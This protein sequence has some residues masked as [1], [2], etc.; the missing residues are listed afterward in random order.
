[1]EHLPYYHGFQFFRHYLDHMR[2]PYSEVSSLTE[3]INSADMNLRNQLGIAY[4]TPSLLE[5]FLRRIIKENT[6]AP[7]VLTADGSAGKD[8]RGRV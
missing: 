8:E 6:I 7:S 4:Q 3:L 5:K 2:L 1:M